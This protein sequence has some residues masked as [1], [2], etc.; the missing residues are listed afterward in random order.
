M[1]HPPKEPLLPY[2][3]SMD[4][5][6]ISL[7]IVFLEI[8]EKPS[9]LSY[10]FQE[11]PAG[12][13]ILNMNLEVLCEVANALADE[14]NLHLWR[15]G[16]GLMESELLNNPPLL[17]LS[18]SYLFSVC[19]LRLSSLF[20]FLFCNFS[21]TLP[22]PCKAGENGFSRGPFY[23]RLTY[24]VVMTKFY[25]ALLTL[26]GFLFFPIFSLSADMFRWL[27]EKGVVHFTD[28]LHNIPEKHRP[29]A[30]RIKTRETPSSRVSSKPFSPNRVSV[31]FQ[32]NGEVVIVQAII[33]G[34]K[35]AN[36]VVDT[37]ATYTMISQAM[38]KE[39]G[40]DTEKKLPTIRFQTANGVILAPL[41]SLDSIA[42][43]TMK[44]K[45]LTA[46]IHDVFPDPSIE[47]L[48]GL[49]FLSNFRIDIDTKNGILVLEK[50]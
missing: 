8:I 5:T 31:P 23:D 9:P 34:K 39:L 44:V 46:A 27:D 35:S 37:G 24:S 43:G 49:N 4:Q 7:V 13:V 41:V 15:A 28:N 2:S 36:F 11:A 26:L 47:G 33:N 30:T 16:I 1:G 17:L 45:D 38:A 12:V 6:L 42:V 3:Q 14:S 29:T 50:K 20:P 18:N 10:K 32:K 25:C 21:I 22:G 19:L 48:L 40:I